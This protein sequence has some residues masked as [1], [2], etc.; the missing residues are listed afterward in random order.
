MD[1]GF[2]RREGLR[3]P[4]SLGKNPI[5]FRNSS[6]GKVMFSQVSV[7]HSVHGGGGC[8]PAC[9]GQGMSAHTPL[10]TS[11][12]QTP[13]LPPFRNPGSA[14][15]S[16]FKCSATLSF[17]FLSMLLVSAFITI[18]TN[19]LIFSNLYSLM[20]SSSVTA[21]SSRYITLLLYMYY[22]Q[23]HPAVGLILLQYGIVVWKQYHYTVTV[24][25]CYSLEL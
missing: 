4:P 18:K 7:S 21:C 16:H 8:I 23:V 17:P 15:D 3:Q 11:P 6:Y 5:T 2:P 1:S 12:G 24:Q 10:P 9:T 19:I 22:G 20:Y 14:L 13:T 25:Y